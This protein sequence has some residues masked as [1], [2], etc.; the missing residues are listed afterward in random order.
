MKKRKVM[1]TTEAY[2][3]NNPFLNAYGEY[4]EAGAEGFVFEEDF[5]EANIRCIPMVVRFKLDIAGIKLKLAEWSR[6]TVRDRSQLIQGF[7]ITDGQIASYRLYLQE[8]I[9]MRTGNKPTDLAVDAYPLWSVLDHVSPELNEKA[10][11]FGLHI[12][13]KQWKFLSSLQRFTLLKLCRSGHENK[14]FEKAIQEFGLINLP[15]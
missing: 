1:T 14:N 6:F 15:V 13:D 2:H 4:V 11:G 5:I 3:R 9:R 7:C 8:L 10:A 12:S